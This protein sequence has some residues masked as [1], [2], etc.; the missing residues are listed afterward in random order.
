MQHV[1][2]D[3]PEWNMEGFKN[4]VHEYWVAHTSHPVNDSALTAYANM[5]R[6]YFDKIRSPFSS[7]ERYCLIKTPSDVVKQLVEMGPNV[8]VFPQIELR[9]TDVLRCTPYRTLPS[10]TPDT[11]VIE[12]DPLNRL[13]IVH[14]NVDKFI[15]VYRLSTY[16]QQIGYMVNVNRF[17]HQ[18]Y[19]ARLAEQLGA[20]QRSVVL[21]IN[22]EPSRT[23]ASV[24][25]Y[26][27]R[28]FP[29]NV[30]LYFPSATDRALTNAPHRDTMR[31]ASF[32]QC[33]KTHKWYIP[34]TVNHVEYPS[35]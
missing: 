9:A 3:Q 20:N 19:F 12:F 5:A 17:L 33:P 16:D 21:T 6:D 4:A 23:T 34:T 11:Y 8:P 14:Y 28:A 32:A 13:P 26:R 30:H 22:G 10:D 2:I 15:S 24:A 7:S 27:L 25:V 29:G 18:I 1:L 35:Q 31:H